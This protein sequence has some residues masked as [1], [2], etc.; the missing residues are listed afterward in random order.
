M[1][2]C[3]GVCVGVRLCVRVCMCVCVSEHVYECICEECGG[4][5]S[6]FESKNFM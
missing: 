2:G 5:V 3:V 4:G 6:V 1:C